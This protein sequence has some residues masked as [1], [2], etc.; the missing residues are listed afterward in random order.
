QTLVNAQ[1]DLQLFSDKPHLRP[2][3]RSSGT[4]AGDVYVTWTNFDLTNG[5]SQIEIEACNFSSVKAVCSPAKIISG[6]DPL[7]QFSHI[8]VRP[9]GV[10]T[11]TYINLNLIDLGRDNYFRQTFD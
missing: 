11:L 1:S 2:D 4:G 9:D 8:A 10:V 3:E 7:T 6:S 5:L